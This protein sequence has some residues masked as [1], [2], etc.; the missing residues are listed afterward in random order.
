MGL[1]T[2][3]ADKIRKGDVTIAKNYLS[4][5]EIKELNLLVEQYLAFAEAQ[6]LAQRPM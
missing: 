6:A 4:E 5:M 3:K 1:T 2:W